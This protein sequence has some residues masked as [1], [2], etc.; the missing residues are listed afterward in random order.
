MTKNRNISPPATFF[1]LSLFTLDQQVM[2]SVVVICSRSDGILCKKEMFPRKNFRNFRCK[3]I[4]TMSQKSPTNYTF[5][6]VYFCLLFYCVKSCWPC[7]DDTR[8][9]SRRY[10]EQKKRS[11]SYQKQ[12]YKKSSNSKSIK[13][14]LPL[15]PQ[16]PRKR[17][18]QFN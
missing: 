9:R 12:K 14:G 8:Q 11:Q 2:Q 16:P 15:L 18:E 1:F 10:E 3:T 6:F 17:R 5:L 13:Q 7:F 4:K